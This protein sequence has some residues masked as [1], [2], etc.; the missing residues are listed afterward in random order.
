MADP[1]KITRPHNP[2]MCRP[3]SLHELQRFCWSQCRH[4]TGSQL[5]W[6]TLPP[7]PTC[8]AL[9]QLISFAQIGLPISLEV[10][11]FLWPDIDDALSVYAAGLPNLCPAHRPP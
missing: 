4:C 9:R 5:Q 7:V 2:R 8:A 11:L 6:K 10:R 3:L 1:R